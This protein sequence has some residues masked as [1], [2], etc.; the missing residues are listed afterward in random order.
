MDGRDNTGYTQKILTSS[1][2]NHME[3]PRGNLSWVLRTN[4]EL[5]RRVFWKV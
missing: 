5:E 1:R 4:S 3:S 2:W